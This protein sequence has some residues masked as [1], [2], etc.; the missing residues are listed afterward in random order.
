MA[1]KDDCGKLTK[2]L[3]PALKREA[4]SKFEST[5]PSKVAKSKEPPK[6][7]DERSARSA[8]RVHFTKVKTEDG[9]L[10]ALCNACG[11]KLKYNGSTTSS[12][13]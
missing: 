6:A 4:S 2:R 7:I 13:R 12:L 10:F 1:Q 3:E 11:K 5:Q 8:V 9:G